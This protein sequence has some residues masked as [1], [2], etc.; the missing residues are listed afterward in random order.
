MAFFRSLVDF[1]LRWKPMAGVVGFVIFFPSVVSA[2]PKENIKNSENSSNFKSFVSRIKKIALK[3]Q[4]FSSNLPDFESQA[5]VVADYL[6]GPGLRNVHNFEFPKSYYN[7]DYEHNSKDSGSQRALCDSFEIS[8]S[9]TIVQAFCH[10]PKGLGSKNLVKILGKPTK[11]SRGPY[12][13]AHGMFPAPDDPT[14][15][16]YAFNVDGIDFVADSSNEIST[17]ELKVFFPTHCS[18]WGPDY[19]NCA[20]NNKK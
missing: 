9:M 14:L 2:S 1:Q 5:R 19:P 3:R 8:L 4:D 7:F 15:H 13:D 18:A 6:A 16:D 10:N 11:V 20:G 17:K 12:W